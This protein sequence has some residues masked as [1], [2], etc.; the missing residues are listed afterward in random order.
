MLAYK[1]I[2]TLGSDHTL[3]LRELPFQAGERVEV[4]VLARGNGEQTPSFP[5]RGT[6]VQYD[7]PTNPVAPGDWEGASDS[8]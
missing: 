2:T 3:T 1:T 7:D 5:L 4:I 8:A 6:P